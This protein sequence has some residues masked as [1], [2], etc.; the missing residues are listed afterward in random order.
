M[1]E[2]LVEQASPS[3]SGPSGDG[4]VIA[5]AMYAV[6]RW[7]RD[8]FALADS[9]RATAAAE[10]E[11]LLGQLAEKGVVTRGVYSISGF[12]PDADVMFWWIAASSEDLQEAYVR[13]QRTALGR[14]SEPAWCAIGVHREAEFN[15]AHV[16]AFLEGKA[17]GAYVCVY[18]YN[19]TNEWYLLDPSDRASMLREH[20]MMG[21]EYPDVLANTVAAF[22]LGDYE[23]LLA[24]EAP[25]LHRIVDLMRH[26][27]GA[28]ARAHTRLETPFFTGPRR[29]VADI[30]ASIP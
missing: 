27:R 1:S 15:K 9:A 20:G 13:F 21:R 26:L 24:F 10:V 6:F 28:Q 5:Y 25:E 14:A 12:R 8:S 11:E 23:F 7:R 17:P 3:P 19:R 4:G 29:P 30:V 2:Q 16:P 22:A 18:P